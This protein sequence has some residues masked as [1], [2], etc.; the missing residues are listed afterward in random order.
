MT[1]GG[2]VDKDVLLLLK[3]GFMDGPRGPFYCPDSLPI[4]GLLSYYPRLRSDIEV[5]YL[6]FPRPRRV[7]ADLLGEAHQG[8]P[9]LLVRD[10][11]TVPRVK[12]SSANNR[13]FIDDP[14]D[15]L[16]YLAEVYGVATCHC[17]I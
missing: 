5:Q 7:V 4:E 17:T 14:A 16:M 1:G 11:S 9:V 6:D 13:R 15:I 12:I 3:P 2:K 10:G 8:L